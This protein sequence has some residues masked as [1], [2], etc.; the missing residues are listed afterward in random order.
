MSDLFGFSIKRKKEN[1]NAISPVPPNDDD[2]SSIAAFGG[3]YGYYLDLEGKFRTDFELIRKY[4]EMSLH[5]ECDYIIDDIANEAIVSD[6]NDIPVQIELTNVKVGESLKRKIR[7]E[8]DY[9]IGLLDFENK[10]HNIFRRWYID[11]RLF[12][13]KVIDFDNPSKGIVELR[14]IDPLKIKKIT[15]IKN[16]NS[17]NNQE[18]YIFSSEK[19]SE[20]FLYNPAGLHDNDKNSIKIATDAITFVPSGLTDYSR[21]VILSYLHKAIKVLNQLRMLED[22]IV[23]YRLAR[24]SEKRI[25]YIDVGNL[26]KVKAEQYLRD[27]MLR[28]RQKMVYDSCLDMNTRIPLLDGRTLPLYEIEREFKEGKELWVYSA[29]PKTGKFAPGLV[30]FAGVTRRNEEVMKITLDNG[31]VITCTLDHKFPVWNKGKVEAK[32]LI[33]GDSMIPFY[34]RHKPVSSK[35]NTYEKIF[36]NES[37]K[38]KFTHSLVSEWKDYHGIENEY[39]YSEQFLGKEKYTVHHK[40]YDRYDNEP[41]NLVR[42]NRDDHFEYHKQHC[43]LAGKIGGKVS[44]EVQRKNKLGIFG[45]TPKQRSEYG[46][47][48]GHIGGKKC[49]ELKKGIHGLSK[50][51]IKENSIKGSITLNQKLQNDSEFKQK[52]CEAI[53]NGCTEELRKK[54]AKQSKELYETKNKYVLVNTGN[55]A[56]W[57]GEKSDYYRNCQSG[58]SSIK[59]TDDILN[60]TKF[61]AENKFPYKKAVEYIN[62]NINYDAWNEINIDAI[63]YNKNSLNSFNYKNLLKVCSVLGF[64]N[65]RE[66]RNSFTYKNHKIVKIEFTGQRMDVGT[67]GIDKEEKYHDYHTFAL[68]SGIYTCNS[69]GEMKDSRNFMSMMEDYWLPRRDGSKGTEIT[70]LPG[71]QNLG[72]LEDLKYFEKKLYQALNVPASRL[73][74]ESSAFNFGT[75]SQILRDELKFS[76]SVDRLRKHFSLLFSDLLKTQLILKNIITIEDW[77]SIKNHVQFDFLKDNHY[78]ELKDLEIMNSRIDVLTSIEKYIGLYFSNKYVRTNILKQSDGE[79]IEIDEDIKKEKKEKSVPDMNGSDFLKSINGF[80]DNSSQETSNSE[81]IPQEEK[82]DKNSPNSPNPKE[83]KTAKEPKNPK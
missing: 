44:S 30:S 65:W 78:T 60:L 7:E 48:S 10:A 37:K 25:F 33:V 8:F 49:H 24:A 15:E 81:D 40:N 67:L 79:I 23:I 55:D 73:E 36:E 22:S 9:I 64:S 47:L 11:G 5:P 58:V 42:M 53:S 13:H 76:K 80:I 39:T 18:N 83:P 63:H 66:L 19:V 3:H 28:Y 52:Y 82:I 16:T 56:R 20:Y 35:T 59:Y 74:Q 14:Y 4:R 77:D 1:Q 50:E 41:N 32:D 54:R 57:K 26:P 17:T 61:C 68:E 51:Q 38:W 31:Q 72:N 12:Y 6:N 70:T 43:H 46:K 45:F 71:G 27:V 21:D 62:D 29:D 69:T 75:S 2:G 34:R